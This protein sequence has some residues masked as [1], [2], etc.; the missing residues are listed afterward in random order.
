[1]AGIHDTQYDE[2]MLIEQLEECSRAIDKAERYEMQW[3]LYQLILPKYEQRRDYTSLAECFTTLSQSYSRASE[4]NRTNKRLLGTYFRV[5][6]HGKVNSLFNTGIRLQRFHWF[7][8]KYSHTY[9][10]QV[11]G[12]SV[13][14]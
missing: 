14:P 4:A 12:H 11:S 9:R 5:G 1:M 7:I 13:F 10:Q 3:E 6:L 2:D 8:R